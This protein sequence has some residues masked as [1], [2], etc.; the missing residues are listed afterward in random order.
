MLGERLMK[1]RKAKKW[2][3]TFLADR[4]GV[5]RNSIVNWET[6]RREPKMGDIQ[7]LAEELEVSPNYLIGY[8]DTPVANCLETETETKKSPDSI[9][10]WGDVLANTRNVAERGDIQEINAISS[11]LKAALDTL[12][13]VGGYCMAEPKKAP[14]KVSAYNG[15]NSNYMGNTLNLTEATA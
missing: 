2:T 1:L 3:Q 4:C 6:G 10:Y 11:L 14:A 9:A 12:S 15:D 5:S 7:K 13:A 8:D